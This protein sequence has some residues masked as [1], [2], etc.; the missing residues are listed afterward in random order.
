MF[1]Q[2]KLVTYLNNVQHLNYLN[3]DFSP[4]EIKIFYCPD[5]FTETEIIP[6]S[7]QDA[8]LTI[9]NYSDISTYGVVA[10]KRYIYPHGTGTFRIEASLQTGASNLELNESF[11]VYVPGIYPK[12][13]VDFFL[14]GIQQTNFLESDVIYDLKVALYFNINE[15]VYLDG[16][17]TGLQLNVFDKNAFTK[18]VGNDYVFYPL[19]K[20]TCQIGAY[21]TYAGQDLASKQECLIYSAF[22]RDN[23]AVSSLGTLDYNSYQGNTK[24]RVL[25][26]S[27]FELFDILY[28][29]QSDIDSI[30]DK[31]N[32][33]DKFL[34][35][36]S[37]SYGLEKQA[38]YDGTKWE[39][40]Y[41]KMYRELLYNLID[42]IRSRGTKLAYEL[43][44][45]ALG[46]D[47]QLL[48]YWFDKNGNLVEIDPENFLNSTFYPY[49]IDGN[50][51]GDIQFPQIDPRKDISP[52]N[53]YNFCQKSVYVRPILTVKNLV[54]HPA[55]SN[56]AYERMLIYKYLQ[57]LKP[58]HI[59]YLQTMFKLNVSGIGEELETIV[60]GV[61]TFLLDDPLSGF[62]S[63]IYINVLGFYES[64]THT[65]TPLTK[66]TY[67]PQNNG[68]PYWAPPIGDPTNLETTHYGPWHSGTAGYQDAGVGGLVGTNPSPYVGG[69]LTSIL[70]NIN[71]EAISVSGTTP[72]S[73]IVFL[74]WNEFCQFLTSLI[75]GV[76]VFAIVGGDIRCT[77]TLFSDHSSVN[78][79]SFIG[80][81]VVGT[82]DGSLYGDN[83]GVL[84]EHF[85]SFND[86]CLIGGVLELQES[87]ETPLK[88]DN[89]I[90]DYDGAD[91]ESVGIRYDRGLI[92][93]EPALGVIN[94]EE[95]G[96]AYVAAL[97][98]TT[99]T[100]ALNAIALSYGITTTLCQEVINIYLGI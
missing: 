89:P 96:D 42:L 57:W 72:G 97:Q 82:N 60:S 67:V 91:P 44:F 30:N 51:L 79:V 63:T 7:G 31:M 21:Y 10:N 73:P 50:P 53:K 18:L 80:T 45:G 17:T 4:Y 28:A 95:L 33:K 25:L 84:I 38:I 76:A 68:L 88:Y 35:I 92:F 39:Y 70:A 100:A 15:F 6:G 41:N 64:M 24:F 37:N 98:I 34:T 87:I 69:V 81:P 29:Y 99:K 52:N 40:A 58:N 23:F 20:G 16:I 85:P 94:I 14:N 27:L 9:R 78:V 56:A 47:I 3:V 71:G 22:L 86:Q 1:P 55:S 75:G 43:F 77:S 49:T 13:Q 90:Y 46:Y 5:A 65:L 93:D 26:K 83:R 8:L 61:P 54:D 48:E 19:A 59:E 66:L 32:I 36:M 12:L 11:V 62:D 74:T 2:I